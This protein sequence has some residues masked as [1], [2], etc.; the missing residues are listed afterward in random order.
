MSKGITAPTLTGK[1]R[2]GLCTDCGVSRQGSGQRLRP[3]LP[4]RLRPD[5]RLTAQMETQ[6]QV[7]AEQAAAPEFHASAEPEP[8]PE[9]TAASALPPTLTFQR[10]QTSF[11]RRFFETKLAGFLRVVPTEAEKDMQIHIKCVRGD[12]SGTRITRIMPNEVYL[13]VTKNN[14]ST[15]VIIPFAEISLLEIRHKDA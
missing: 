7:A 12:F 4:T 5:A 14:A 2:P 10:G 9:R 1:P 3:R 13:Q 6:E 8:V 11:N 15:D